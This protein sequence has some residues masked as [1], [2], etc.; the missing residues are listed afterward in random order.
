LF[1]SE[2]KSEGYSGTVIEAISRKKLVIVNNHNYLPEMLNVNG[3]NLGIIFD[4]N[5][6]NNLRDIIL[7]L[8]NNE[9]ELNTFQK[10]IELNYNYYCSER[11]NKFMIDRLLQTSY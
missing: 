4:L 2:W 3:S 1:P 7:N 6:E 5:V 10:A 11:W 9:I 8:L